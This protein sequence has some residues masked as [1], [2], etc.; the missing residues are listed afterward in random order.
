MKTVV[1]TKRM[2]QSG[3]AYEG[4]SEANG[5]G[6]VGGPYADLL[7]SACDDDDP[8][9][10]VSLAGQT[11]VGQINLI[12]GAVVLKG[13]RIAV[14]WGSGFVVPAEH[15]STGAGL[16]IMAKMRALSPGSGAVSISQQALPLYHKLG[17]IDLTAQRYLLPVRPST[18]LRHKLGRSGWVGALGMAADSLAAVYRAGVRAALAVS[19]PRVCVELADPERD[20][21]PGW[22]KGHTT[23]PYSTERSADWLRR[24]L[25]MGPMDN[26]RQLFVVRSPSGVVLGYFVTTVALR[27]GVGNGRFGDLQVASLRD[28][29]SFEPERLPDDA[30]LRLGMAELLRRS[31]DVIELCIPNGQPSQLPRRLGMVKMGEL[32]FALRMAPR[33]G[34]EAADLAKSDRWWFRPGDGDAFLL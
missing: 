6:K 10:I 30:L 15:R 13:E 11:P 12:K 22:F 14:H 1:I 3:S 4:W 2:Y 8:I 27:E 34:L 19:R 7:C 18:F 16:A 29:V 23:R 28:W 31:C 24:V 21:D 17:W 5:F 20:I 33:A 32:H 9:S 25:T 26:A